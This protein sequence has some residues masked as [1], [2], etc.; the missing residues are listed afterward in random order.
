MKLLLDTDTC[1]ALLRGHPDAVGQARLHAPDELAV[2]VITRYELMVGVARCAA[3]R[4]ERERAKVELFL[5]SVH[6]LPFVR[7][8]AARAALIRTTLEQRGMPIGPLDVLIA[9]TALEASVGLITGNLA[10]FSRIP[11]LACRSWM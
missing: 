4:R 11:D 10:E 3:S 7:Q 6:E 2:S 5:E 9:A 1:I 8:T